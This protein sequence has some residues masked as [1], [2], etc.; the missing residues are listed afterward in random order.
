MDKQIPDSLL[1]YPLP[2]WE[3]DFRV[4][5]VFARLD[6]TALQ[7]VVPAPL[8]LR[9]NIV[10]FSVMYFDSSVPTEP[11]YDAAVIADVEYGDVTGGYWIS[12]FT[13][14]DLVH[15]GAIK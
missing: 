11:Y 9:S 8:K 14:T 6:E 5:A 7:A 15:V 3:H 1:P 4:L 13:S 2:P 10:Q 12:G